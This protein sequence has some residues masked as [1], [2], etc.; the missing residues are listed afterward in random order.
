MKKTKNAQGK[1]GKIIRRQ[2][3]KSIKELFLKK[4]E[5]IVTILLVWIIFI[6]TIIL[7]MKVW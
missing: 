5:K 4:K 6:V 1:N 7:N 2:H 3:K